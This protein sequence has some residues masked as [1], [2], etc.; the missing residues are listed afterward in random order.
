MAQILRHLRRWVEHI[1]SCHD[2]SALQPLRMTIIGAA[3]T[4]KSVMINTLVTVLRTMFGDNDVVHIAAPTGTAAFN[5]G[6]ETLHSLFKVPIED[7]YGC[8]RQVSE[9]ARKRL[10]ARFSNTVAILLDERSMVS[11]KTLGTAY[12]N[13]T[14][15]AHGGIHADEDWG[16]IPI[17]ILFGDDYQ[18]PPSF[19]HG[20]FDILVPGGTN[21]STN[22]E[23]HGLNQFLSCASKVCEL[24]TVKRTRNDQHQFK[25]ILEK[26]RTSE[27]DRQT[28]DVLV[29]EL[30]LLKNTEYTPDERESII[31]DSLFVSANR[32]PVHEYNLSRLSQ[33]CSSECPVAI[34]KSHTEIRST[35][36]KCHINNDNCPT[37]TLFCT[38]S[39][40]QICGRNFRPRWGLHNGAIGTVVEIIFPKGCTPNDDDLPSYVVVDF[41]A[42]CGPVW[43]NDRPTVSQTR[44]PTQ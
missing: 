43:D 32:E 9:K 4:G 14:Q 19:G 8:S 3:G 1:D 20:P 27:L 26:S 25:M 21:A 17:V 28:A 37:G 42:Y 41:K 6:G 30:S 7:R 15:C 23:M 2:N 22:A 33:I 5:V 13:V 18:L 35:N 16:G 39:L 12:A 11:L 36:N 24:G 10:L 29:D 38:H 40:V 34:M 31:R 44:Y